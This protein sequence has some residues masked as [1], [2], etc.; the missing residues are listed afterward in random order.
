MTNSNRNSIRLALRAWLAVHQRARTLEPAAAAFEVSLP[1]PIRGDERFQQ[2][3]QDAETAGSLQQ[4][5]VLNEGEIEEWTSKAVVL[6][7][8][9]KA[10]DDTYEQELG[11]AL[12]AYCRSATGASDWRSTDDQGK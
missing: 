8:A 1:A 5:I 9:I 4:A 11:E 7:R 6:L 2:A 10:A 12:D 3:L